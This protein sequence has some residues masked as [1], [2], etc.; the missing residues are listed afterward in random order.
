[1]ILVVVLGEKD[2]GKSTLI[3]RLL[4]ETESIPEDRIR[5]VKKAL[6]S[7]RK[8]FEWAHLLD[9]FQY[10]REHEMT[11]DSTRANVNLNRRIFEF[12]DVPGHKELIKNMITGASEA[13]FAILV[14]DITE[15]I[16]PQTLRHLQIAK[17]LGIKK[18]I[19]A[20]NKVDKINY[21]ESKYKN[22]E[23]GFS[24]T[25]SKK[26]FGKKIIFIPISAHS[27]NNLT[28]RTAKLKWFKG[29]TLIDAVLKN[30]SEDSSARQEVRSAK[31]KE[32]NPVCLFI[33]KPTGKLVLE[34]GNKSAQIVQLSGLKKINEIEKIFLS[35]KKTV[36]LEHKCIIKKGGRIVG[37]CK[38]A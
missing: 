22:A 11:L 38:L 15:G 29:S 34:S 31:S 36:A 1:M 9:S 19:V 4:Y 28:N 20:V 2:H 26:G 18:I 24:L 7:K 5:D 27:G 25:L 30:F 37:L 14:I 3:G 32:L 12:I 17:F 23:Q 33:E 10:E 21:S 13:K 35:L 8:K 6:Q 16:K